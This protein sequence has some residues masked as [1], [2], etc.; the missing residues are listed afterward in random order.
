MAPTLPAAS[1]APGYRP[2]AGDVHGTSSSHVLQHQITLG[3][4][5]LGVER[6]QAAD[7]LRKACADRLPG[8]WV[9]HREPADT[10][11]IAQVPLLERLGVGRTAELHRGVHILHHP[12]VERA[13]LARP[14]L[15]VG[16]LFGRD[17]LLAIVGETNLCILWPTAHPTASVHPYR[18]R[19]MAPSSPPLRLSPTMS[20]TSRR[21]SLPSGMRC[22]SS[23]VLTRLSP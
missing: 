9:L 23:R 5:E 11:D 14:A 17:D 20:I 4:T 6:H 15:H 8:P 16:P 12:A 2:S 18:A 19:P 21:T 13:H 3:E 22:R 7:P 1:A 10:T